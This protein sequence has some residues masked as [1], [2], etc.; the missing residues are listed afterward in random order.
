MD[1]YYQR[2]K[3][4]MKAS[5]LAYY[6]ANKEHKRQ[7]YRDYATNRYRTNKQWFI[8]YYQNVVKPKNKFKK[9]GLIFNVVSVERNMT[10]SF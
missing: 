7:Y 6:H 2:N 5:N 3:E 4:K 8:D 10:V 1:T 9:L